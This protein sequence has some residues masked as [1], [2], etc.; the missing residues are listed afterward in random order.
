MSE[1]LL[2]ALYGGSASICAV[3]GLVFIRYWKTQRE[4]LFVF[5]ALA[6]WCFTIGW[7]IRITTGVDDHRVLVFVPR[8][9]GFLLIIVGIIDKNRRATTRD[10]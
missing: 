6:F 10:G 1:Q 9:I 3:I 4:R 5:F 2:L 8:L 7:S